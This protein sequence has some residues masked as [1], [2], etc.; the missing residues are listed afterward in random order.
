MGKYFLERYHNSDYPALLPW[1][2]IVVI[3]VVIFNMLADRSY[4]GLDPRVRVE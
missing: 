1:M 3:F 4:A 2:M